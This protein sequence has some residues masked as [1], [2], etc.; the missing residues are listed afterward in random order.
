[1]QESVTVNR[2]HTRNGVCT[3]P[4]T[5]HLSIEVPTREDAGEIH[6]LVSGPKGE[7][8]CSTLRWAGPRDQAD[9]EAWIDK[10]R[11]ETFD[12]FG[13]HWIVR[14]KTAAFTDRPG[15]PIG[16]IGTR[17]RSEPG[18]ADVGYWLGRD[19]WGRGIMS[20][21]LTALIDFGFTTLDFY[22]LEADVFTSN[23]RGMRL[24]EGVGMIREGTIRQALRKHGEWVD[25]A[26]FACCSQSGQPATSSDKTAYP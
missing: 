23:Q 2:L 9:M 14:D 7:E 26:V 4:G 22:K 24:V 17:P 1:M 6:K 5:V 10:T 8:V 18:R 11:Q 20:E 21:A 15:T 3:E 19:F 13:F 16:A 12:D 25:H